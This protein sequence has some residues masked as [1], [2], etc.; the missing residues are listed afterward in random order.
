MY[1]ASNYVDYV[2]K[3]AAIG[4][5]L[6]G[7]IP[8]QVVDDPDM[9]SS[10]FAP[11]EW[12]IYI[13]KDQFDAVKKEF[14][15]EEEAI[16][17]C[18]T[19]LYHEVSHAIMTSSR[20]IMNP[21]MNIFEDERI[22]R[23]I[24][25]I[26]YD[27]DFESQ[28][29]WVNG[30]N[31]GDTIP[32]DP[33]NPLTKFYKLVRF[34][35]GPEK[36]VDR[37][38]K[39]IAKYQFNRDA[40]TRSLELYAADVEQLFIDYCGPLPPAMPRT[41]VRYGG[42]DGSPFNAGSDD[43]SKRRADQMDKEKT[44]TEFST[45]L[46]EGETSKPGTEPAKGT[47]TSTALDMS[48]ARCRVK[49]VINKLDNKRFYEAI[50]MILN[51]RSKAGEH[52]GAAGYSGRMNYRQF[53]RPDHEYKFWTKPYGNSQ[54]QYEA[55]HFI[56]WID[57]SGSFGSSANLLNSIIRALNQCQRKYRF[58]TFDVI[59]INMEIRE[60]EKADEEI[61]PSGGNCIPEIGYQI[62]Q[63]HRKPRA[64]NYDIVVFDGDACSDAHKDA[65]NF[66]IWNHPNAII[67]ADASNQRYIEKYAP[68]ARSKIITGSYAEEF[69]ETIIEMLQQLVK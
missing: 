49:N 39:I 27:T 22:E 12:K 53:S 59:S 19:V 62:Y 11:E 17:A 28:K 47:T 13:K 18:R 16:T 5:Y 3:H 68:K 46:A 35:D 30:L 25:K 44:P 36:F 66:G 29:Y 64:M 63:K 45:E 10:Y 55:I 2:V 4:F 61:V 21:I 56:L 1:K 33:T 41:K 6:G 26:F 65:K 60:R 67:V 8:I 50:K 57:E 42:K 32:D 58:F 24:G 69:L 14:D 31:P 20:M 52:G 23:L 48:H 51:R 43:D 7:D 40:A 38:T 37:V 54:N 15:T 9:Y 34:H